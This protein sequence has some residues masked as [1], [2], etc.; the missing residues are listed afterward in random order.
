VTGPDA[1]ATWFATT[2]EDY[3]LKGLVAE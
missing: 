2:V 1:V 3:R